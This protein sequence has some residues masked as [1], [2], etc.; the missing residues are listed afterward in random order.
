[1][2]TYSHSRISTFEQC[3]YKYKL[4][5]IDRETPE[6]ENTIEAF[7]GDIVHQSLQDLYKRKKFKQR[8]SKASLIKFYK[9]LWDKEY[10]EDIK[11][12]KEGL[13]AE[14][15]R[16]M[17]IKFLED[18]Y[19]KYAPFEQLTILGLETQDRMTLS[20]GSQWHVRI[21]KFACDDK[22]NYYVMDYKTNARMKD[23]EE[24]DSDRQLAMYSIWVKD[25]FKDCKS[26]KLIWHMLAFNKEVISER[27]DEELK[28]LQDDVIKVIK[29]IENAKEYPTNVTA[30]CDYCGFKHVCP[31]FKHQVELEAKED[32]KEFKDDEGVKLV[33]NFS[34]LKNKLKEL[35]D[36]EDKIKAEL[37]EFA[38]QKNID[39]VYGS[40]MKA[41]VKD[42]DKLI[43][44]DKEDYAEFIE[45]LKKKGFWEE[46]SMICYPR[47]QSK[48]VKKELHPDL[49]E[50]VKLEKDKRISLSKRKDLEE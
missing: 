35:Q 25:K 7:M 9:D 4:Q 17:G 40:N 46:C 45:L 23:Q 48:A 18:Y 37:I 39:I 20:D 33:D 47:I 2:A 10:S 36:Q 34:E 27:T 5:Y 41:S 19:N 30:L 43:L 22:G 21:D 32:V 24:A 16:K 28:K 8:I 14:N 12:V 11:V 29:D 42:F 3:P 50:K 6:I 38:K 13:T 15:Y 31:S 1:M 44:P 26:V 49:M